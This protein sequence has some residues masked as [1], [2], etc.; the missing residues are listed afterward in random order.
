MV[1]LPAL[2]FSPGDQPLEEEPGH[3]GLAGTRIVRQQEAQGLAGQYR[4]VDGGDLVR[5][6]LDD[7]RVDGQHGVEERGE[8]D[9]MGLGDQAKRAPSPS[10]L[11]GRPCSTTS[12]RGSSWR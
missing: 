11:Q 2:Q 6:R 3:D 1:L 10:K 7:G 5:Q 8:A 9:A 12:M 4:V